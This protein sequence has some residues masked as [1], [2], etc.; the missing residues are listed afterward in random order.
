MSWPPAKRGWPTIAMVNLPRL[1]S[2]ARSIHAS[3]RSSTVRK[4]PVSIAS[5]AKS[6]VCNSKKGARW[7]P[8]FM[9]YSRRR[10]AACAIR[11]SIRRAFVPVNPRS[12]STRAF[13]CAARRL[14]FEKVRVEAFERIEPVMIAGDRINRLCEP[15]EREIKF[16]FIVLD[17]S[18]RIDDVRR[19]HEK[20]YV[21][22][23]SE[24]QIARGQRILR[25]VAFAR[26]ADH[27]EAEVATS[28]SARR[29]D[30]KELIAAAVGTRHG[31][32]HVGAPWIDPQLCQLLIDASRPAFSVEIPT[33]TPDRVKRHEEGGHRQA[34]PQQQ[35]QRERQG[36]A[37]L[38][39]AQAKTKSGFQPSTHQPV[40]H[41]LHPLP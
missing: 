26:I 24:L 33:E 39:Q 6:S 5:R 37:R 7:I 2:R 12:A 13:Y 8:T 35:N 9:A 4:M 32:D 41:R 22:A 3:C 21:I 31:I 14:G 29:I 16:G 17:S 34:E 11:L 30:P 25:S 18:G 38:P 1:R 15:L 10:R 40:G 19:D 28:R 20:L 27:E 23:L 36:E